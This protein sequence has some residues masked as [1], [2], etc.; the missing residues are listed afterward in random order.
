M[1][2]FENRWVTVYVYVIHCI[3][4]ERYIESCSI[5]GFYPTYG[6]TDCPSDASLV[7]SA[8]TSRFE[9]NQLPMIIGVEKKKDTVLYLL[10]NKT[11]QSPF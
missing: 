7:D 9:I 1:T 4:E 5:T 8:T 2:S 6:R 10:D 11:S 3:Y